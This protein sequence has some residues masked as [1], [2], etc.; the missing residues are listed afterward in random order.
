MVS[1]VKK[2]IIKEVSIDPAI[3]VTVGL[4][5]TENFIRNFFKDDIKF[6]FEFDHIKME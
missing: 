3:Q 5:T 2:S 6:E 1:Q 4:R